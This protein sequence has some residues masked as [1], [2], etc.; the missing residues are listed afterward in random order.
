M[1]WLNC[2]LSYHGERT[3]T[4]RRSGGC[5]GPPWGPLWH[6]ATLLAQRNNVAVVHIVNHGTSKNQD[7]MHLAR[8]L[9]FITAKFD[10]HI[11]AAHIKGAL[12][13]RADALSH[14]NL[15]LF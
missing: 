12:N 15:P 10:F 4:H 6:G 14:N 11:V 5:L 9:A 2:Q 3:R 13:V 8:C 7:A 1:V